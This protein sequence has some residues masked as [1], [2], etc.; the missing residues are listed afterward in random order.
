MLVPYNYGSNFIYYECDIDLDGT[1]NKSNRGVCKVVVWFNG[2]SAD[3]YDE[4]PVAVY[5]D[6][7]YATFQEYDHL[8]NVLMPKW[9]SFTLNGVIQQLLISLY[10]ISLF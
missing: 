2:F 9:R 6:D 4:S 5:T 7:H 1:Y 10:K 8:E 3:G